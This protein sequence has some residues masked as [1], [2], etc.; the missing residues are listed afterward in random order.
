MRCRATSNMVGPSKSAVTQ[1]ECNIAKRT[2]NAKRRPGRTLG[3]ILTTKIGSN[4]IHPET[5]PACRNKPR[6]TTSPRH[7]EHRFKL[8][9]PLLRSLLHELHR[10]RWRRR[11]ASTARRR[12]R[13]RRAPGRRWWRRRPCKRRQHLDDS[14]ERRRRGWWRPSTR[15]QGR[16]RRTHLPGQIKERQVGG[17]RRPP[18][19]VQEVLR[20][21]PRII[22]AVDR[23]EEKSGAGTRR[24]RR[25]RD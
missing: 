11:R 23:R 1:P 14:S 5:P 15:R 19:E 10:R 12:R 8:D 22:G 6:P 21:R 16:R 24:G 13:R 4:P 9:H 20:R 2:K 3:R 25:R 7:K 18:L 17:T